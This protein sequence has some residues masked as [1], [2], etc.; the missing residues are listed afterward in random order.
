MCLEALSKSLPA[1]ICT[2]QLGNKAAVAGVWSLSCTYMCPS[3]YLTSPLLP[4]F[5][6][7]L[8][9]KSKGRKYVLIQRSIVAFVLNVSFQRLPF[10]LFLFLIKLTSLYT[11]F[12]KLT[13]SA[14]KDAKCLFQ[15]W[16]TIGASTAVCL[17]SYCDLNEHTGYSLLKLMSW[18]VQFYSINFS[19][20]LFLLE[21]GRQETSKRV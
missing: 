17:R 4:Y 10:V 18:L 13:G 11:I 14:S 6:S 15:L 20:D 21:V 1:W 16:G 7:V 19:C 9:E 12:L 3:F 5:S 8:S 2:L